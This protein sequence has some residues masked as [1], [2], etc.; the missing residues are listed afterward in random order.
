ME[1]RREGD[2]YRRIQVAD[3]VFE[4]RYGYYADEERAWWEPTPIFPDFRANP[5]YTSQGQPFAMASQDV[6]GHYAPKPRV[7]GENW[8]ND[9]RHFSCQEDVIGVCGC[10][11]RQKVM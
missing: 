7:S 2:L 9:C 3:T 11:E 10:R 1:M 4:I 6:C 8:C 5:Q